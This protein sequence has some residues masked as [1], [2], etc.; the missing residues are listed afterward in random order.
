[1][2]ARRRLALGER[3]S[4]ATSLILSGVVPGRFG[5]L[6]PASE[7]NNRFNFDDFQFD[8]VTAT[9]VSGVY[10]CA[11]L[12]A[13]TVSLLPAMV[14]QRSGDTRKA[15]PDHSVSILLNGS[16]NDYQGR[17][18]LVKTAETQRQLTGNGYI[19]IERN[20][21]GNPVG[22]WPILS[23]APRRNPDGT[24]VYTATAGGQSVELSPNDVIH[25]RG[26][27]TMDGGLTGI[28][29]VRAA[30]SA[31]GLA[32]A[33]ERFAADFFKNDAQTGGIIFVPGNMK[34]GKAGEVA[35]SIT[36]Q[37]K[38]E[39]GRSES[40]KIKVFAGAEKF[41]QTSVNAEES[42]LTATRQYQLEEICRWYRVPLVLVQSVEKTTS[43]GSGVEQLMIGFAQWTIAP[44]AASLEDE[45]TR[46][47][48]TDE[49]RAA[50]MYVHVDLRGIMKGDQSSRAL[51]YQSAIQ[52]SWMTPN[53]VRGLEQLNPIEGGDALLRPLNMG[54]AEQPQPPPKT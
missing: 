50:G 13:D 5:P 17:H 46:K 29:P 45:L 42:Q 23:A 2:S 44:L 12:L 31:V 10:S 20:T 52:N 21:V 27:S 39:A 1:M 54:G 9:N 8:E 36:D 38:G 37:R 15:L 11:S 53:E 34:P 30:R 48:L 19:Q 25:I 32:V 14:M 22:L 43:W 24:L 6:V 33:M 41:V 18:A 7:W 35:A 4:A 28:S 40:H 16:V 26:L 49:E 51:F 3:V 47:L